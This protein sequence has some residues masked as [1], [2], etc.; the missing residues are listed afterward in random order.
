M[1]VTTTPATQELFNGTGSQTSFSFS[2]T[3]SF[4]SDDV[5]VY[6]WNTTTSVWDQKTKD[7]DYTQS[8]TSIDFTTA[9]ASGTKNVLITRKTDIVDPKVDYVPGSS[10]RAQ[11]LDNNQR[12]VLQKLQELENS[13]LSNTG[14]KLQGNLDLN[15]F[16]I[17]QD[18][19][20][21]GNLRVGATAPA[22]PV[23]GT[24]WF[25][26]VSG[27]T[28][29]YY[30]DT[31]S[32]DWIDT[33]PTYTQVG[34]S[35]EAVPLA[36]G[37][38]TGSLTLS[39]APTSNLHA[40]TKAYVDGVTGLSDGDKGDITVASSGAS[41]TIDDN[42]V[43]A[44]AIADNAVGL[45]Q[46]SG[47]AKGGI[48]HGNDSG[49]PAVLT[50]GSTDEVLKTNSSGQI[51]WGS[52]SGSGTVTGVT[53]G[54]GLLNGTSSS[55]AIDAT[56]PTGTLNVDVGTT[57]NKILQLDGN[58]KIPAV[59][60]SLIT[61]IT[62][63]VADNSITG[64]KIALGSD[65]QGDIMYYN[66]T[67]YVRL[68][69]GTAAQ[70]LKVNAGATA[71][72]WG[73]AGGSFKLGDQITLSPDKTVTRTVVDRLADEVHLEDFAADDG[74]TVIVKGNCTN[75]Q[76]T[77]N[78]QVFQN[79]LNTGKTVRVPE[80]DWYI[81]DTLVLDSSFTGLIGD[82]S[83]RTT[84]QLIVA[85]NSAT[86]K[87]AIKLQSTGS[88]E[89]EYMTLKNL[90]IQRKVATS[91]GSSDKPWTDTILA[92][93]TATAA[94]KGNV[95]PVWPTSEPTTNYAGVALDGS[96]WSSNAGGV[97][98]PR[99]ENLRIGGFVTGMAFTQVVG[100]KVQNSWV[101]QRA[102]YN[103]DASKTGYC[104]GFHFIADNSN[105]NPS[106]SSPGHM[107]PL[108]SVE[109]N[110]CQVDMTGTKNLGSSGGEDNVRFNDIGFFLDGKDLRDIFLTNCETVQGRYGFKIKTDNNDDN[111]DIHIIRPIIDAF[112]KNAISIE[113]AGGTGAINIQGGYGV[114]RDGSSDDIIGAKNSNGLTVQG[115]QFLGLMND[116][117]EDDGINL[118]NCSSCSI[119]GNR[120]LNLRFGTSLNNS[121]YNT[122]VGNVYSGAAISTG[123]ASI[124]VTLNAAIRLYSG[125]AHNTLI[126][127]TIKG[128]GTSTNDKY[129][130]GIR[131]DGSSV[132]NNIGYGNKID[133]TTV[134]STVTHVN[135]A[136]T[137][138]NILDPKGGGIVERYTSAGVASDTGDVANLP[139]GVGSY[140]F[141]PGVQTGMTY[142]A[143]NSISL[144][145]NANQ[146][147]TVKN[148]QLFVNCSDSTTSSTGD[149]HHINGPTAF[150]GSGG[151]NIS[152]VDSGGTRRGYIGIHADGS[153][154]NVIYSS[155][156][157]YRLKENITP[158]TGGIERLKN[159]KPSTFN[160]KEDETKTVQDG[161]IA[162]EV[163][164]VVPQAVGG[165]KDGEHMQTLDPAKL[166]PLLTAAL[167]ELTERVE[168]LEAK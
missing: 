16:N 94:Q 42:A 148:S 153:S 40:A 160:W 128:L 112:R 85:D 106:A 50:V 39:G 38:M 6:V 31:D 109:L 144:Y 95:E 65:T 63:T 111:W 130:D 24:R 5:I 105:T 70:V 46:L 99:I 79:A 25:D 114:G 1:T 149:T 54:T 44:A 27:R 29:I 113:G 146:A 159:L 60:G 132:A 20:A 64:A 45:S 165:E 17:T 19:T 163:Q 41:W 124:A 122:I 86:P 7:T 140:R 119:V 120:F 145:A 47:I 88:G 23:N 36:G 55:T 75:A 161:F 90:H 67:D 91:T 151:T 168:A 101:Q 92:D 104:V 66:G 78:T 56:N 121:S 126:G 141:V 93:V 167:Q 133:S 81:N 156:S 77:T 96:N 164:E 108:A 51:Q 84:I 72:E 2:F 154:S 14:A 9:P 103:T 73:S 26:T 157:D 18:G 69:K 15:D 87:P 83:L 30:T 158:L 127:N 139:T 134:I 43:D 32:S 116:G 3:N 125:S 48:I 89:A 49:D 138:T 53:P 58:A 162:H 155:S 80:G 123:T 136:S 28:Y 97:S 4:E 37:T 21:V 135:N 166:V 82:D 10:I 11:D 131:F 150:H 102:I 61:N 137:T 117:Q 71:P 12:Q 147:L 129:D 57:A 68:A 59:D 74:S 52:V 62:P 143:S 115:F 8:G 13:S 110:T 98:R 22:N 100:C 76:V 107:S 118:E 34:T 33:T 35:D 142:N 152:I